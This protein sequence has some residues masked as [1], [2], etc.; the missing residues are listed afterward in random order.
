MVDWW[1]RAAM[2]QTERAQMFLAWQKSEDQLQQAMQAVDQMVDMVEA[3]TRVRRRRQA[4]SR[5]NSSIKRYWNRKT[6]GAHRFAALSSRQVHERL[7][8]QR[9]AQDAY[10]AAIQRWEKLSEEGAATAIIS[11]S[12]LTAGSAFCRCRVPMAREI[13]PS[14]ARHGRRGS[15][16]AAEGQH[17]PQVHGSAGA[18]PSLLTTTITTSHIGR[19]R[20]VCPRHSG[21]RT[22][23][24][25]PVGVMPVWLRK[26]RHM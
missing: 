14:R 2:Y 17:L 19:T 25:Y 7:G 1:E 9:A 23:R 21:L 22:C 26:T 24:R 15:C 4:W 10:H 11:S 13:D 20:I 5:Q 6:A 12:S 18:S 3:P 8:N 16:R